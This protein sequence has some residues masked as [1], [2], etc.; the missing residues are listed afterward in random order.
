M[1]GK[2]VR[3]E[4]MSVRSKTEMSGGHEYKK[5]EDKGSIKRRRKMMREYKKEKEDGS[6]RRRRNMM[7][8][9]KEEM[10]HDEGV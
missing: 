10:E 7:R 2:K 8:E 9:Y 6:I 3:R 4:S 5:E 1:S